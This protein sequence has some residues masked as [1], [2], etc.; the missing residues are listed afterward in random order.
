MEARAPTRAALLV[1]LGGGFAGGVVAVFAA[2]ESPVHRAWQGAV[3]AD[4]WSM[5]GAVVRVEHLWPTAPDR[6]HVLRGNGRV[7]RGAVLRI[8]GGRAVAYLR[9]G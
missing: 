2:R 3:L 4:G 7:E 9:G 6:L 8:Q 5:A 1:M